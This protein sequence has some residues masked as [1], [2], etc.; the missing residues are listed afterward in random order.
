MTG[1]GLSVSAEELK[2]RQASLATCLQMGASQ[3]NILFVTAILLDEKLLRMNT[4]K[5][6]Y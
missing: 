2:A 4:Q 3:N 6:L 1:Y 5:T